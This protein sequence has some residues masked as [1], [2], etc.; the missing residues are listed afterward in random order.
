MTAPAAESDVPDEFPLGARAYLFYLVFQISQQRQA[1][2][3]AD[4]APL[5]LNFAKWR[6]L[7]FIERLGNCSM[8]TLARL[9]GVH[10]TT[11]TRSIDRM[12]E[13]GLV[14]RSSAPA[15]R[16]RVVLSL[17]TA[18]KAAF[19]AAHVVQEQFTEHV[20]QDIPDK[21]QRDLCRRLTLVL[22]GMIPEPD[23]AEDILAF[24]ARSLE[25]ARR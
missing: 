18:G 5:G 9:S 4:L 11:L 19:K 13:D 15:D 1:A 20:L 24:D 21:A 25:A 10:R 14:R 3:E 17:T 2:L 22:K 23:L 16:R 6:S 12:V 7:M 8:K